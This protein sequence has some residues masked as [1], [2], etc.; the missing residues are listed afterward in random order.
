MSNKQTKVQVALTQAVTANTQVEA[1]DSVLFSL[2]FAKYRQVGKAG[3]SKVTEAL[4]KQVEGLSKSTNTRAKYRKVF[5]QAKD[6]VESKVS[7]KVS[8]LEYTTVSKVVTLV[9]YF[10][11]HQ[12]DKLEEVVKALGS[13]KSKGVSPWKYNNDV[14]EEVQKLKEKYKLVETEGEFVVADFFELV[15]GGLSKLTPTQLTELLELVQNSQV[16]EAQ[17]A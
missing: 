11:K 4:N 13:V 17:V 8:Y 5:N 15:K 10:R 7:L 9:R 6:F 3:A 2:V 16:E 14:A 12:E 1:K